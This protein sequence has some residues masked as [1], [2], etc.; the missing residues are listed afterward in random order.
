MQKR[1]ERKE[2]KKHSM[3]P[4]LL[5]EWEFHM[6]SL[7]AGDTTKIWQE[8]SGSSLSLFWVQSPISKKLPSA[9]RSIT[10]VISCLHFEKHLFSNWIF[11]F[12]G[13]TCLGI[14]GVVEE[15]W[16]VFQVVAGREHPPRWLRES[17]AVR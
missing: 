16:L 12:P 14:C 2:R 17:S 6:S 1:K 3:R 8:F 11:S 13:R 10:H 7:V 4:I 15:S 9:L 5:P